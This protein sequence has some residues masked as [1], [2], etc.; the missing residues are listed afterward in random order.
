MPSFEDKNS[1]P[2]FDRPEAFR[3]IGKIEQIRILIVKKGNRDHLR[4][5]PR[6]ER[7]S[8][9]AAD[10]LHQGKDITAR[11]GSDLKTGEK[12]KKDQQSAEPG[13]CFSIERKLAV[14]LS[15]K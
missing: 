2:V 5:E 14:T 8:L 13:H 3:R 10:F 1:T 11:F 7:N 9:Q 6:P 15:A 12:A 4:I